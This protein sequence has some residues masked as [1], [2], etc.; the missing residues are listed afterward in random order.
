MRD[1]LSTILRFAAVLNVNNPVYGVWKDSYTHRRGA[2]D[3]NQQWR[4][5]WD[6]PIDHSKE[7]VFR[8]FEDVDSRDYKLIKKR[9]ENTDL[10][11]F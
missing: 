3:Y 6:A 10:W 8:K 7:S 9:I 5:F 11:P 2:Y 1:L 4:M